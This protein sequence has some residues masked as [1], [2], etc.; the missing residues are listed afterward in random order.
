MGMEWDVMWTPWKTPGLEHLHLKQHTNGFEAEGLII[1]VQDDAP[2][3]VQYLI[4]CDPGWTVQELSVKR[5]DGTNK[6]VILHSDGKGHWITPIGEPIAQLEG[7]IDVDIS[8]T[9]FTNTLPIK[10]LSLQPGIATNIN[11]VYV[12]VPSLEIRPMMQQYTCL[13]NSDSGGL[14]RYRSLASGYIAELPTDP[15][16]LVIDYPDLFTRVWSR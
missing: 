9:P 3:R 16:G 1:G 2:F 6:Q 8:G 7:C 15:N 4:R 14:F 12:Q 11:V 10:R 5:V 13:L